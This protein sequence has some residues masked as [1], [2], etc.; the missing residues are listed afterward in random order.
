MDGVFLKRPSL[1]EEL[2]AILMAAEKGRMPSLQGQAPI[3]YPIPRGHISS[4]KWTQHVMN[5]CVCVH[6]HTHV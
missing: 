3:C 6:A 1:D 2:Q 5:I 4:I